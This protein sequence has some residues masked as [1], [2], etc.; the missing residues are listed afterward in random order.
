MLLSVLL[1]YQLTAKFWQIF[2]LYHICHAYH[3]DW[4]G[5]CSM[6]CHIFGIN[7]FIRLTTWKQQWPLWEC[8]MILFSILTKDVVFCLCYLLDRIIVYFIWFI[9]SQFSHGFSDVLI[10]VFPISDPGWSWTSS[11]LKVQKEFLIITS[12]FLKHNIEGGSRH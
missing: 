5:Y 8:I 7:L 9:E 11:R 3:F 10:F 1:T 6:I 2:A 4:R 12:S